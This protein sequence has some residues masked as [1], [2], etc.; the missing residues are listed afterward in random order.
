MIA[1]ALLP[2]Y[3]RDLN[4]LKEE[5]SLYKSENNLWILKNEIKN[6]SGTLALHLL[7]NL[8][9][10]IGAVLDN[11]GYVRKREKEFADKNVPREIILKEIEEVTAILQ[12][13][14]P[15]ISDEKFN[16]EYPVE[17]L[18]AKRSVGEMLFILF[19]HLNYHLGQINYHRRLVA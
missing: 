4:K 9:Y 16:S 19:G 17:F 10:F 3:L 7:G 18:G 6:S 12:K 13:V 5:I 15:A 14:F 1:Q 2:L 8:N 11:T